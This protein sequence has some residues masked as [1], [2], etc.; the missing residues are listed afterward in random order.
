MAEKKWPG[1]RG[2]EGT[3]TCVDASHYHDSTHLSNDKR[4]PCLLRVYIGDFLL[5]GYVGITINPALQGS[6]LNNQY[7]L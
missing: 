6:L 7:T 2:R 5:P 3:W 4:A 1:Q